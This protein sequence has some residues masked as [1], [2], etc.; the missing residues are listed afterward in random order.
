MMTMYPTIRV[1]RVNPDADIPQYAYTGD[2]GVDLQVMEDVT[3]YPGETVTV[4]CGLAFAIPRGWVGL[5]VPRSSM[6][7][8][9]LELKNTVGVID[10]GYRDEVRLPLYNNN[11]T[12][13]TI[14][15][16]ARENVDEVRMIP[17]HQGS[18]SVSKGERVA[19][20]LFVR[21]GEA[22]ID[23]A[24]ALDETERGTNGFG[25]SGRG[26]L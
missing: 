23:E 10:S 22:T 8:R 26:R 6:G 13:V 21:V 15:T 14:H 12:H 2:A 5:I 3:L 4:G 16:K 19:Q 25:S 1:K 11:P 18:V 20:M 9:G 24:D 7:C 17:N